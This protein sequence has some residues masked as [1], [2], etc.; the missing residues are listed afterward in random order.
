MRALFPEPS[1]RVN[2]VEMYS[3][4]LEAGRDR[5]FVR[6]NMIATLDGATS[7]AGRSGGL[8]GPG[9]SCCSR[10]C[11]PSLTWSWS[12]PERLAPNATGPSNCR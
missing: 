1:V 7:F 3:R 10:S 11:V 9:T 5:P 2:L 12:A 4:G 8:G 6:V